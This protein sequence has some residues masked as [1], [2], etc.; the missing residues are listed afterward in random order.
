MYTIKR[1]GGDLVPAFLLMAMAAV[2]FAV[3]TRLRETIAAVWPETAAPSAAIPTASTSTRRSAPSA[4]KAP[5]LRPPS[6][7]REPSTA[8]AAPR[9]AGAKKSSAAATAEEKAAATT[10]AAGTAVRN[11]IDNRRGASVWTGEAP[12]AGQ[13]AADESPSSTGDH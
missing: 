3:S 4:A 2:S 8:L 11:A 12:L 10:I 13:R 9:C 6:E 7:I 5:T 1:S